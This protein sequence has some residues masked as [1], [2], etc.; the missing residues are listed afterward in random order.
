MPFYIFLWLRTL[1]KYIHQCLPANSWNLSLL[2]VNPYFCPAKDFQT[3]ASTFRFLVLTLATTLVSTGEALL[4]KPLV[5]NDIVYV[6]LHD[7]VKHDWEQTAH[8]GV[9]LQLHEGVVLVLVLH[10]NFTHGEVLLHSPLGI[11]RAI[12]ISGDM[13]TP[14]T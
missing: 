5:L 10:N 7:I 2:R 9:T 6:V 8:L 11:H 4:R 13:E 3:M 1:K 12:N 14:H